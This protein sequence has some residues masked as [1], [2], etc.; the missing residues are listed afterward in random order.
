MYIY[1]IYIKIQ[2]CLI[3]VCWAQDPGL[4]EAIWIL[5]WPIGSTLLVS[6]R[7]LGLGLA[8][9]HSSEGRLIEREQLIPSY[10]ISTPMQR[11]AEHDNLNKI[12]VL[13]IFK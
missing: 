13:N 10:L 4:D 9:S 1:N 5:F 8:Y 3:S 2:T 12:S 11:Q 6:K 7:F